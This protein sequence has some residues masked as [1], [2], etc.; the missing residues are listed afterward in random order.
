MK[1]DLNE[2][3]VAAQIRAF[4][5]FLAP[6]FREEFEHE[7]RAPKPSWIYLAY[8]HRRIREL[9]KQGQ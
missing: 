7:L 4:A 3:P 1:R 2:I 6:L 8:L 5:R 9:E